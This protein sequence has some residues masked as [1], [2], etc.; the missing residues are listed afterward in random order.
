MLEGRGLS[1]QIGMAHLLHEVEVVLRPG[2]LLAVLGPNGA[3]KSTL[4]KC[5]SGALTPTAGEILLEGRPLPGWPSRQLARRRAVLP[6]SAP[7]GDFVLTAEELVTLGRAP[8]ADNPDALPNSQVVHSALQETAA[9]HLIDRDIAS[10]SGG[11]LQ[12]VELARV[13]AQIWEARPPAAAGYLLLDEP[14]ASLDQVQQGRILALAKR[15]ATLGYAVLAIVHDLTAALEQADEALLLTEGRALA[16]GPADQVLTEALLSEAYGAP[17]E[18][19]RLD[20]SQRMAILP[21]V[22]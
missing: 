10:L 15:Y 11:E 3:G 6:Q 22:C 2:R 8:H 7:R 18:R 4:L 20:G 14:T 1:L 12:R 21:A 5:L 16:F 17:M 9:L 19:R 13:L